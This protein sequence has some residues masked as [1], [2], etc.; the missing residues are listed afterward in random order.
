MVT[1]DGVP[2]RLH[3]GDSVA[4]AVLCAGGG[5]YRR[6]ILGNAPR[7]PFCMMGV[8]FECLV[9]VDGVPNRQGC[10]V[11]ARPGMRIVRQTGLPLP[12]QSGQAT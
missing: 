1:V 9:E 6:T 11:P 8:C 2:V 5:P 3:Q 10:L 7:A 12:P 4:V